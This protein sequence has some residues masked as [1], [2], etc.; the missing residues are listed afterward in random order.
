M[1]LILAMVALCLALSVRPA[2][3]DYAAGLEAYRAGDY[4][5]ALE[6]LMPEAEN[7]QTSAQLILGLIYN[8]GIKGKRDFVKALEW[9]GKAAAAGNPIA[10]NNLGV[11]YR[12]GEGIQKNPREAFSWFWMAAMQG[13]ATGAFNLG[14]LYWL[15]EGTDRDPVQA[16]VWTDFA[17]AKLPPKSR[18]AAVTRR[19]E[20][21]RQLDESDLKRAELMAKELKSALKKK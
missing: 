19:D 17:A 4:S 1:R 5:T 13:Y 3:A 9:Y 16:Y 20:I 14:D 18:E 21:V 10:Q 12:H 8:K 2:A 6:A 15:G 7:G 11:M